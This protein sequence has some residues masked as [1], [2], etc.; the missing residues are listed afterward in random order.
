MCICTASC[1]GFCPH[2]TVYM[3]CACR[4]QALYQAI[5]VSIPCT[6]HSMTS[7]W[8]SSLH[9]VQFAHTLYKS[10]DSLLS[11]VDACAA[12]LPTQNLDWQKIQDAHHQTD[13]R[14]VR[15]HQPL[16]ERVRPIW[17][18]PQLNFHLSCTGY[19]S[20]EGLQGMQTMQAV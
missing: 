10:L 4:R 16:R 20:G 11:E 8:S 6:I 7:K 18:W 13:R 12:G 1:Q 2:C 14:H 15:L 3:L 5:F 17:C 9:G 19:G